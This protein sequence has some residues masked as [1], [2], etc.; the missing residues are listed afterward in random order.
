MQVNSQNGR[1][2]AQMARVG[3]VAEDVGVDAAWL[4]VQAVITAELREVPV[5]S[6]LV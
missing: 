4:R 2:E 1:T 3:F 6:G 5:T